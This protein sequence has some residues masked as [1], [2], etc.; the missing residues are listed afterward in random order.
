MRIVGISAGASLCCPALATWLAGVGIASRIV[1]ASVAPARDEIRILVAAEIADATVRDILIETTDGEPSLVRAVN[2]M[3]A[4][5]RFGFEDL[6]FGLAMIAE[7]CRPVVRP[8]VGE[9]ESAIYLKLAEK[10]A[11]S[12][13]TVLVLGET[14]TGK[15]GVAR[16]IHAVSPR[17]DKP[18]IA[19]NCAALPDTM[20]EAILFGHA[21]GAFTGA[22]GA[23]EGL[24]RAAEG[25]TLLLDEIAE[26]PLGLQAKLLRAIQEREV[27]PVGATKSVKIDVRIIAAAN[28]ELATEVAEGRFRADLYWRLNVM[29]LALKPLK[30]RRLDIRAITAALILRHTREGESV[31]WPTANALD[32][33]MAH[34]WP[35]NVRELDNVIQRALL[36]RMGDRIE[37]DDLAIEVMHHAAP[38]LSL[39]GVAPVAAPAP[40]SAASLADVARASEMNAIRAALEAAGGKRLLAAAKLGISERTLRYRLAEMRELAAA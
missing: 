18:F 37:A 29:P 32:R 13:A 19:V 15:E 3:P 26:M 12:D 36:L 25:G 2:G 39:V 17:A 33:L 6:A 14:G 7:L 10:V 38:S 34:E 28:R 4:T 16:F 24:F 40:V 23:S 9:P 5:I 30:A 8:A 31:A 1:D 21:K 11:N 35:G 27:L 22:A 20:L